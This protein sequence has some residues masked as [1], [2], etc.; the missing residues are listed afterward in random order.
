[1]CVLWIIKVVLCDEKCLFVFF[2]SLIGY[3]GIE[4]INLDGSI[5]DVEEEVGRGRWK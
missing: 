1:M 4:V 3:E 5:E 2:F